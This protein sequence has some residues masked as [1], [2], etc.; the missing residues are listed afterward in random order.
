MNKPSIRYTDEEIE[1]LK[2]V[3]E[4]YSLPGSNLNAI[5]AIISSLKWDDYLQIKKYQNSFTLNDCAYQTTSECFWCPF[6][7]VPLFMNT[8][9]EL[10]KCIV[11]WRLLIGK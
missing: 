4:C 1:E 6:N 2:A 8:K 3:I 7:D 9:Y 5:E 11:R 10:A